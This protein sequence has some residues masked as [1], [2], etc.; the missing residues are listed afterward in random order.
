MVNRVNN[1]ILCNKLSVEVNKML[2][3]MELSVLAHNKGYVS[4]ELAM[5]WRVGTYIREFFSGLQDI[6]VATTHTN[7]AG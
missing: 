5:G 6:L 4:P 7:D 2:L 1:F 3:P